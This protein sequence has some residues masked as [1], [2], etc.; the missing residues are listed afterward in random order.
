LHW[1][2]FGCVK[3]SLDRPKS[4]NNNNDNSNSNEVEG[5]K[6]LMTDD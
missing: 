5:D 6:W 1:I 2:S 3:L 4:T